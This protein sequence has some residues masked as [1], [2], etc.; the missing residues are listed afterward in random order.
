MIKAEQ[1]Q[2]QTVII[3]GG[4]A[5]TGPLVYGGWSGRLAEL[6]D[7]GVALVEQSSELCVGK[8]SKYQ[9]TAN[10]AASD[11]IDFLM[12]EAAAAVFPKTRGSDVY[13]TLLNQKSELLPLPEIGKLLKMAGEDLAETF[14]AYPQ[15]ELF[16]GWSVSKVQQLANGQ[17]QVQLLNAQGENQTIQA[18]QVLLATGGTPT[19]YKQTG[20]RVHE[21]AQQAGAEANP[22]IMSSEEL[23]TES[24]LQTADMWLNHY[25]DPQVVIVGGSHSAFSSAWLLNRL[26][27]SDF[28]PD[29]G[30]IKIVHRAPIKVWYESAEQARQDGYHDFSEQDI[31]AST[32]NVFYLAGLKGDAKQLYR[33]IA[34][35][36]EQNKCDG[37]ELL[38]HASTEQALSDNRIDWENVA[39]VI[40][41]VVMIF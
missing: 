38:C 28:E 41:A 11:F 22:L 10:T 23:L 27:D 14:S 31:C 35:L 6:L 8:L 20:K 34:G 33:E 25:D 17:Y 4:P 1:A 40:F 16:L 12:P 30:Q 24:G 21:L 9:V 29:D 37:I 32:K 5:G 19:A 2:F 18:K 15:S 39:L 13:Q 3:G 7:R 36:D 26:E